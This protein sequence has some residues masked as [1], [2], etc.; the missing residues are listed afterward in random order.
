MVSK[1]LFWKNQVTHCSYLSPAVNLEVFRS[2]F[3]CPKGHR[4][5]VLI[6]TKSKTKRMNKFRCLIC[7]RMFWTEDPRMPYD[8]SGRRSAKSK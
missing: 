2:H 6:E 1:D 5:S 4:N 3:Q 8:V 7:G